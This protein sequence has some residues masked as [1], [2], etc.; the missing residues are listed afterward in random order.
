MGKYNNNCNNMKL[1]KLKL[2]FI[3]IVFLIFTTNSIYADSDLI[4]I[5]VKKGYLATSE[6]KLVSFDK[7]SNGYIANYVRKNSYQ[8]LHFSGLIHLQS[9]YSSS[10]QLISDRST[11]LGG[12]YGYKSSTYY[13]LQMRRICLGLKIDIAPNSYVIIG[14]DFI[15]GCSKREIGYLNSN[16]AGK[17]NKSIGHESYN[18]LK[19]KINLNRATFSWN[20]TH[21]SLVHFGYTKVP[22]GN[23]ESYEND[24]LKTIE[25][26]PVGNFFINQ[27]GYGS[28]HTGIHFSKDLE[29]EGS[30]L[31]NIYYKFSITDSKQVN[32]GNAMNDPLALWWK[33]G[34]SKYCGI[35]GFDFGFSGGYILNKRTTENQNLE[36]IIESE[37]KNIKGLIFSIYGNINH[38][39]LSCMIQFMSA[40]VNKSKVDYD[41]VIG[42]TNP[43]GLTVTPSYKFN[44]SSLLNRFE[45]VASYSFLN[46]NFNSEVL[47]GIGILPGSV[48][49]GLSNVAS[50]NGNSISQLFQSLHHLYIGG[51][52][53]IIDN[54]L[55]FSTGFEYSLFKYNMCGYEESA[56]K[57]ISFTG[58]R[59]RLQVTF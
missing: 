38:E 18:N 53:F 16:F 25:I 46:S 8:N 58:C 31:D 37:S 49:S 32:A 10:E 33:I 54:V 19:Y 42:N 52:W 20:I 59:A 21:N 22:F 44:K 1:N 9:D 4:D 40:N 24:R 3:L 56:I 13:G 57:D 23:E 26:S 55:T 45:A 27:L 7:S 17:E 34:C 35:F 50:I 43:L 2:K 14:G 36:S 5:L 28:R 29:I 51:N 30:Y 48:V 39:Q 15:N 11:K 47:H 12:L 41:G 6:S